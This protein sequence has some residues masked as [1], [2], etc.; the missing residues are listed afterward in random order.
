MPKSEFTARQSHLQRSG[1]EYI[2]K[3]RKARQ[4]IANHL[5]DLMESDETPHLVEE[6]IKE[7]CCE[8]SSI[9]PLWTPKLLRLAYPLMAEEAEKAGVDLQEANYIGQEIEAGKSQRVN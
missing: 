1:D 3:R 2:A 7:M 6:G 9:V 5:A 4:L 8:L